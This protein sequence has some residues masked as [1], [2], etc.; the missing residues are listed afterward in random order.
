MGQW[1]EERPEGVPE[2]FRRIPDHACLE[3]HGRSDCRFPFIIVSGFRAYAG[4]CFSLDPL[5]LQTRKLKILH[6]HH[7][8]GKI[9]S[10]RRQLYKSRRLNSVYVL[11]L[12]AVSLFGYAGTYYKTRTSDSATGHIIHPVEDDFVYR[13]SVTRLPRILCGQR[14]HSSRGGHIHSIFKPT[15]VPNLGGGREIFP[16]LRCVFLDGVAVDD[17][18]WNLLPNSLARCAPLG[19]L[20]MLDDAFLSYVYGGGGRDQERGLAFLNRGRRT[21]GHRVLL[22]PAR[23]CS[24]LHSRMYGVEYH[25]L[26]G[27]ISHPSLCYISGHPRSSSRPLTWCFAIASS[28]CY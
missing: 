17:C 12:M 18:D 28:K 26:R 23:D 15:S 21:R 11:Q 5:Q 7:H 27:F 13:L 14:T 19:C 9:L 20:D 4:S 24:P 1:S 8:P 3:W 10:R 2:S 25:Q 22:T 6:V 16:S